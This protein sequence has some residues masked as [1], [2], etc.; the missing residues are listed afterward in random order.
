MLHFKNKGDIHP[1]HTHV[2]DHTTLLSSGSMRVTV[3][4]VTSEFKAPQMIYIR[5]NVE[6]ELEAL[7]DN[8]VASCI[9]ALR[10]GERVEDILD[11]SGVPTGI[12]VFDIAKPLVNT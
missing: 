3:A 10:D 2:F 7:E 8:T 12:G 4:G 5:A 1:G 9:H 6:H 11:P